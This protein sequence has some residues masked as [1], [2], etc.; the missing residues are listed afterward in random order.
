MALLLGSAPAA[1]A[2]TLSGRVTSAGV[3]VAGAF[4]AANGP[5]GD[6]ATTADGSGTF[7]L[8][9]PDG[10]YQLSANAPGYAAFL[11]AGLSVNG[12]T[13]QN[14]SLSPSA[15]PLAPLAIFG[16]AQQVVAGGEPGVFY[17]AG[18]N[19]G[20]LY[21]TTNWGGTWTPVNLLADD[22]AYGLPNS[23]YPQEITTSGYP[24]EVAVELAAGYVYYSTNY[25]V[26]WQLIANPP[27]NP[28]GNA[29]GLE[30]A[31]AGR[32][33]VLLAIQ[34]NPY[35]VYVADMTSATPSFTPMSTPYGSQQ[36]AGFSVADGDSEPWLATLTDSGEVS[37]YPLT[38]STRAPAPATTFSTDIEEPQS[39]ALGGSSSGDEPPWRSRSA[40]STR[41]R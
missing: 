41:S 34:G 2:A 17:A 23:S 7:S 28:L 5:S 25:G 13:T 21:R 11:D 40:A 30:W 15:T 6:D 12:P 22:P 24:G 38:A 35:V 33:S 20:D 31:H 1:G 10:T 19:V 36:D 18:G 16:G 32:R 4:V 37:V 14:I 29:V 3:P 39:I 27:T 26:T 8:T 9:V